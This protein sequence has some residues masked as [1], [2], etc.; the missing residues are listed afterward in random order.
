MKIKKQIVTV[1]FITIYFILKLTT[2]LCFS[3]YKRTRGVHC[4]PVQG[5]HWFGAGTKADPGAN[6][7]LPFRT[8]GGSSPRSPSTERNRKTL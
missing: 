8:G 3:G 5:G 2:V 7:E 6:A 4:Y 1:Y